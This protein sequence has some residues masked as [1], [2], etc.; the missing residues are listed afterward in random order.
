MPILFAS[1]MMALLGGAD[2]NTVELGK[3][4]HTDFCSLQNADDGVNIK[5]VRFLAIYYLDVHHY[6]TYSDPRCPSFVVKES[7]KSIENEQSHE[8][9][10]MIFDEYPGNRIEADFVGHIDYSNPAQVEF[11]RHDHLAWGPPDTKN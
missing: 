3:L 4:D 11:I 6:S 8:F 1:I 10:Q 7:T 5:P 2:A 9:K